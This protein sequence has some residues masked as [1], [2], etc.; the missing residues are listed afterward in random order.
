[1]GQ[2]VPTGFWAGRRGAYLNLNVT[3]NNANGKW[4]QTYVDTNTG[5][6]TTDCGSTCPSPLYSPEWSNGGWFFDDPSRFA[7]PVTWLAQ[8]SYILPGQS[9]AAFT[10]QWG[11]TLSNG[12]ATPIG[13]VLAQPWAP[14]QQLINKV[15][16]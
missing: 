14:Q 1:M 5:T 4:V 12:F 8:A 13:P 16:P 15:A 7:G 11:F 9:G 2:F 3:G 10:V 6:F